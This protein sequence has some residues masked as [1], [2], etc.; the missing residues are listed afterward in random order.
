MHPGVC[1]SF[2]DIGLAK[3]SAFAS[4]QYLLFAIRPP[5]S[6]RHVPTFATTT[7]ASISGAPKAYS[8]RKQEELSGNLAPFTLTPTIFDEKSIS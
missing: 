6:R 3:N 5:V 1:V 7:S 8:E 4:Y 2:H